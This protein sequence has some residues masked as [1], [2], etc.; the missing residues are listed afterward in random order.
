MI[1]VLARDDVKRALP[2]MVAIEAVKAAFVRLSKTGGH[3]CRTPNPASLGLR[4]R[5][6]AGRGHVR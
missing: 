5:P 3:L 1:R 2:M 6:E 4:H